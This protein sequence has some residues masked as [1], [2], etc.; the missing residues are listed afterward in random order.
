[1]NR[2]R[3]KRADDADAAWSE[4]NCLPAPGSPRWA[5]IPFTAVKNLLVDEDIVVIGMGPSSSNWD[6]LV[7]RDLWTITCN[8]AIGKHPM[9]TF[10]ACYETYSDSDVWDMIREWAPLFCFT[11]DKGAPVFHRQIIQPLSP[12]ELFNKP[13]YVEAFAPVASSGFYATLMALFMGCDT[14]GLLGTIDIYGHKAL[15]ANI[16]RL[17]DCY[18]GLVEIAESRGQ[19][20]LNIGTADSPLDSIIPRGSFEDIRPRFRDRRPD[21]VRCACGMLINGVPGK[22]CKAPKTHTKRSPW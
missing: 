10:A 14:V 19:K 20:L 2:T 12:A 8:R 1:M 11:T 21:G 18:A 22:L 15:E 9:T 13:E 17:K 16:P 5:G 3:A 4:R 6:A 7:C